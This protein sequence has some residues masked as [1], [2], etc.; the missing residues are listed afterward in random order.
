ME[1]RYRMKSLIW[2]IA[3]FIL[4]GMGIIGI[5]LDIFAGSFDIGRD[6]IWTPFLFLSG[7]YGLI[8]Y[9]RKR[10]TVIVINDMGITSQGKSLIFMKWEDVVS[11]EVIFISHFYP[12]FK[13]SFV[14]DVKSSTDQISIGSEVN[15]IVNLVNY[16]KEKLG[17]K[18]DTTSIPLNCKVRQRKWGKRGF[19]KG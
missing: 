2:F 19:R 7:L 14:I 9:L 13:D 4:G 1:F 16:M 8:F 6:D 3:F 15:D 5:I 11:T 17:G 18:F 10:K 12:F